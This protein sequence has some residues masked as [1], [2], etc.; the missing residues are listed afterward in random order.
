VPEIL[1]TLLQK[2]NKAPSLRV[3]VIPGWSPQ[4]TKFFVSCGLGQMKRL[5]CLDFLSKVGKCKE[6]VGMGGLQMG[7]GGR[8]GDLWEC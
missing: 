2:I 3:T 8:V 6:V 4:C 1:Y 5:K 7:N